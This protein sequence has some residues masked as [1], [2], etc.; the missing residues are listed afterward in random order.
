VH[1]CNPETTACL[2]KWAQEPYLW[3]TCVCRFAC[4]QMWYG[5]WVLCGMDGDRDVDVE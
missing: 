1:Y 4:M 3:N 2:H 5:L